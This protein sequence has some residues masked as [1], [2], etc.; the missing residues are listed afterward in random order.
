MSNLQK[1][2]LSIIAKKA[3]PVLLPLLAL[4][5]PIFAI[6]NPVIGSLGR[7][8][9]GTALARVLANIWKAFV[10]AGAIAFVLYFLWG[11]FRWMT[12]ESDKAK[13]ESGRD[14]ITAAL[15]GLVLLAASVAI[16]ELL[17]NLLDIDFLQ[18]LS[19]TFPAP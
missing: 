5:Q 3:L 14:K 15:T 4:P 19:F 18:R 1:K 13:F 6:T 8:D 2:P 16:V 10:I 9:F 7:G 11:A 12:A 17:G